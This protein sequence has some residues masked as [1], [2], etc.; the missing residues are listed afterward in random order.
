MN[1]SNN[2]VLHVEILNIMIVDSMHNYIML[3]RILM[4]SLFWCMH[5]SLMHHGL[6]HNSLMMNGRAMYLR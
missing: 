4:D 6:V 2:M 1:L 3:L 5:S